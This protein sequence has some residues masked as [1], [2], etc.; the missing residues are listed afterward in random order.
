MVTLDSRIEDVG[1]F[2]GGRAVSVNE[3]IRVPVI[4]RLQRGSRAHVYDTALRNIVA[5]RRFT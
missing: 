4:D 3:D 2:V 5:L 1:A